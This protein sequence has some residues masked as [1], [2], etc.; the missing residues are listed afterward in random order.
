MTMVLSTE[1]L[2]LPIQKRYQTQRIVKQSGK[3]K[4]ICLYLGIQK[5]TKLYRMARF[6][7][8]EL[9][10][11]TAS[12][13]IISYLF[14][15]QVIRITGTGTT[16]C[17]IIILCTQQS[18]VLVLI[19]TNDILLRSPTLQPYAYVCLLSK[20]LRCIHVRFR[21]GLAGAHSQKLL[22]IYVY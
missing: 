10:Y 11:Y 14:T 2:L 7:S 4:F 19:L 20:Y 13:H 8:E 16:V 9:I 5:T 17:R 3:R 21:R 18:F 1:C 6:E 12:H 22:K 15:L